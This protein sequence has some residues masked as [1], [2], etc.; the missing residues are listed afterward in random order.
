MTSPYNV[1]VVVDKLLN[2]LRNSADTMLRTELVTRI[3][4]LA[5]RCD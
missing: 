2:F 4:Q 3:T 5:E 1:E